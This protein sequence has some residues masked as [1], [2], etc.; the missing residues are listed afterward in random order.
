M[1]A[2]IALAAVGVEYTI[3]LFTV[4]W[5]H[6][7]T[8]LASDP[9]D[10]SHHGTASASR[11]LQPATSDCQHCSRTNRDSDQLDMSH[12]GS[13]FATRTPSRTRRTSI[14]RVNPEDSDLKWLMWILASIGLAPVF[15]EIRPWDTCTPRVRHNFQ[16]T[17]WETVYSQRSVLGLFFTCYVLL[18]GQLSGYDPSRRL[19]SASVLLQMTVIAG[20]SSAVSYALTRRLR[21]EQTRRCHDVPV[22]ASE[23]A[24]TTTRNLPV[25]AQAGSEYSRDSADLSEVHTTASASELNRDLSVTSVMPT[26]QQWSSK[27]LDFYRPWLVHLRTVCR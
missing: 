25:R 1:W 6:Y 20:S 17:M 22:E 14:P 13:E 16:G 8:T 15:F 4:G 27:V 2:I 9:P 26:W 23:S 7:L 18:V 3:G 21:R 10:T 12:S 5:R 11:T 24:A 19:D